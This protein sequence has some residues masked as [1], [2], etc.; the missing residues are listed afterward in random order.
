M[1]P[2]APSSV[3]HVAV[4]GIKLLLTFSG[5]RGMWWV[6]VYMDRVL[7]VILFEKTYYF[8]MSTFTITFFASFISLSTVFLSIKKWELWGTV[9]SWTLIGVQSLYLFADR[10][11][12]MYF[13]GKPADCLDWALCIIQISTLPLFNSILPLVQLPFHF[14]QAV[15][16]CNLGITIP[17]FYEWKLC[18][19]SR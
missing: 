6:D 16:Y 8:V 9:S 19:A 15:T 18:A 3:K 13:Q 10:T 2:E 14:P 17:C 4:E 7:D 12:L 11:S 5:D 1:V